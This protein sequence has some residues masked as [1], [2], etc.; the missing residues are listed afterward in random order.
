M[1]GMTQPKL[2]VTDQSRG[3]KQRI[4]QISFQSFLSGLS[5]IGKIITSC[6]IMPLD[7]CIGE[8]KQKCVD[9]YIQLSKFCLYTH[10]IIDSLF[11]VQSKIDGSS[12]RKEFGCTRW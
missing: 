1:P 8:C 9:V 6:R 4:T 5:C 2:A 3:G 7:N 10:I 12:R 11:R